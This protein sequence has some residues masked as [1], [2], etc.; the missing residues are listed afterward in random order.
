[1]LFEHFDEKVFILIDEYDAPINSSIG[2]PYYNEVL[3][4]MSQI[5]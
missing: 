1:M 4:Y 5:Y 3:S 2:K